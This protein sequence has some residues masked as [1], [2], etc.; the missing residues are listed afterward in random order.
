[1]LNLLKLSKMN[2]LLEFIFNSKDPRR[3]VIIFTI[4]SIILVG[5]GNSITNYN[6]LPVLGA[7]IL[8][9]GLFM[10]IFTIIYLVL[11]WKDIVK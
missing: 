3:W 1:M 6:D 8:S 4:V 9:I 2:K 5:G 10:C 11:R 7:I